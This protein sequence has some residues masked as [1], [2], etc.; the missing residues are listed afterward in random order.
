MVSS[1]DLKQYNLKILNFNNI[2]KD[3]EVNLINDLCKFNLLDKHLGTTAKKFFYHHIIFGI[4]EALLSIKSR[5]KCI[6]YFNSTQLENFDILTYYSEEKVLVVLNSI[7]KKIKVL[8]PIKVFISEISFDY[9]NHLLSKND[10][11]S[12]EL[13]S[14]IRSYV[15]SINLERYTFSNIRMFTKRMGLHFLNKEYFNKLKAKQLIIV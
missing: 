1:I 4:C 6:L 14:K 9:L 5:E 15:D 7:L 11:R 13:V 8:L 10:G 2:F 3:I 12:E